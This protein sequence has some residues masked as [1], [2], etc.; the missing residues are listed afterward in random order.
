MLI[1][2]ILSFFLLFYIANTKRDTNWNKEEIERTVKPSVIKFENLWR[3]VNY[4]GPFFH[5]KNHF[6]IIIK[7]DT[8]FTLTITTLKIVERLKFFCPTEISKEFITVNFA[9]KGNSTTELTTNVDCVPLLSGSYNVPVVVKIKTKNW[10]VLPIFDSR[11]LTFLT[12]HKAENEFYKNVQTYGFVEN[13]YTQMLVSANDIKEILSK[14]LS[15]FIALQNQVDVIKYYNYLTSSSRYVDKNDSLSYYLINKQRIF[16]RTERQNNALAYAGSNWLEFTYGLEDVLQP[17]RAEEWVLLHEIAHQYD[18]SVSTHGFGPTVEIWTNIYPAFYQ[19]KFILKNYWVKFSESDKKKFISFYQN[20]VPFEEWGHREKLQFL[21]NLFAYDGTDKAFTEFNIRYYSNEYVN[22]DCII[23]LILEV[24]FDLYNINLLPFL[25]KVINFNVTLPLVYPDLE[26]LLLSAHPVMPAIDFNQKSTDLKIRSREKDWRQS[27]PLMLMRKMKKK[28]VDVTF[29]I[30][31]S[32]D[33]RNFCLYL[34]NNCHNITEKLMNIKLQSDVY[35]IFLAKETNGTLYISDVDYH[36]ISQETKIHLIVKEIKQSEIFLP[37]NYNHFEAL[38]IA[39]WCFVNLFINFKTMTIRIKQGYSDIHYVFE[40]ETYFSISLER[41]GSFI[42]DYNIFGGPKNDKPL[43]NVEHKFRVNDK[44]HIYH[45]EPHR[46][47]FNSKQY[48][49][50]KNNTFVLT[51]IGLKDVKHN[52]FQFISSDIKRIDEFH[53]N[54]STDLSNNALYKI[55][56]AHY[57]RML[58]LNNMEEYIPKSW[59]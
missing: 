18:I 34:N 32:I 51:N 13:Y 25:K 17:I 19:N 45:V 50:L 22:K 11:N 27:L 53:S 16:F 58:H 4:K 26:V 57:I 24:F 43:V 29:I 7:K 48:N 35:S 15:L 42:F 28:Y 20:N 33:P 40:N 9:E 21:L 38:G 1:F 41:N 49:N 52:D 12:S 44:I 5:Y 3:Y 39:D 36:I 30:E 37:L 6:G 55:Y 54:Y 47:R 59:V 10:A 2:K 14:N 56:L 8:S 46:L 23:P 31:S